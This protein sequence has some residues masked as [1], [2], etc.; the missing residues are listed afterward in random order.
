M[1]LSNIFSQFLKG[2][3]CEVFA[4]PFD[5]RLFPWEDKSDDTVVEPDIV[6]I[7]DPAK[8]DERGCNGAPDLIIEILSPSNT[9]K[10]RFLKF[11]LYLKAK[12][13]EYWIVSPETREIEI[14]VFDNGRYFTQGYGVNEPDAKED[15]R[16]RELLPI[17]VLPGLEIDVKEIF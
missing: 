7:C 10:E 15:E 13:R 12:V 9:R 3:P 14:H 2:K 17:T 1:R 11:D 8:I 4:A 6:V 16:I 5:V